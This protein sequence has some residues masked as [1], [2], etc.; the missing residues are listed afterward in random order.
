M[1]QFSEY[2]KMALYN[3]KEN[4][5]RSLL[6]M[7]GIIIGISSVITIVSI[8]NGLKADVMSTTETNSVTVKV[9]EKE[10][11]NT[12][13]ITWDDVQAL[14]NQLE[15]SA[16]GIAM[17]TVSYGSTETRKG[18][19]DAT[20]ILTTPGD[21]YSPGYEEVKWGEYFTD[22]DVVNE[23]PVCVLDKAGAIS[24]FGTPDVVG[25]DMELLMENKI[26]TFTIKGVRDMDAEIM[27]ANEEA[28]SMFG[29]TMPIMLEMPYTASEAW[30]TTPKDGASVDIYLEEGQNEN[31]VAK[32]A[33][34]ILSS[35]HMSDGEDVF[36]KQQPVDM[37]ETM[38]A[39]LDSVTAFVAFVAGI[40]LLVGGIGVMNIMLVSVT[41]RT[42]EIGIRKALGAKT[43]SI[44]IQF[45]FE[46]AILSGIG[47]VIGIMIGAG[48]SG[49]ISALQIGGLSAKLSLTAI[50][51]T[52]CF[53]C[54]VGIVFGIYP[55]RKAAKMS[56]IEALRQL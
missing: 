37:T 54:G 29:M 33:V 51:L 8:G 46:S 22:E 17:Y 32:A 56:P 26:V 31:T 38:G 11:T 34:K 14:S 3:I 10:T 13:L 52:T 18:K 9:D 27:K 15:G 12:A 5:G 28:M 53:S 1:G 4:K 16:K 7:L 49:A 21:L 50:I 24:L 47:G 19:F 6:T 55:A 42:R 35:R 40:S 41:E 36:T 39:L 2:V 30:G 48:I 43:S 44:V 25:M 45:L 20:V 23:N